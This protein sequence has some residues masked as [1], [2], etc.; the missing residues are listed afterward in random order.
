MHDV[1]G[2]L[3]KLG[4]ILPELRNKKDAWILEQQRRKKDEIEDLVD[5]MRRYQ[6]INRSAWNCTRWLYSCTTSCKQGQQD[7]RILRNIATNMAG[8]QLIRIPGRGYRICLTLL[9]PRQPQRCCS[10]L[11]LLDSEGK[12][13]ALECEPA[14]ASLDELVTELRQTCNLTQFVHRLRQEFKKLLLAH[15]PSA[16]TAQTEHNDAVASA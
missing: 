15:P 12:Y 11:L 2:F 14:L 3:N 16:E 6:Q 1:E 10:L 5:L 8:L 9:D 4:Q 7:W 13:K